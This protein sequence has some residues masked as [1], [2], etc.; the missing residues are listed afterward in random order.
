MA[1][2]REVVAHHEAGHAVVAD[3]LRCENERVSI[4]S[5]GEA[6]GEVTHNYGCDIDE[7]KNDPAFDPKLGSV[8]QWV[9]E[10]EA[11]VALSGEIAQRRFRPDSVKEWHGGG[12]RC[13]VELV[14]DYLA[15]EEDQ[16]LRDAWEHVL[17][18]RTKRLVDENWATI[19]GLA[20]LLLKNSTIE[21][22]ENVKEAIADAALPEEHRGKK[23]SYKERLAILAQHRGNA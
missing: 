8:R 21:G 15:G 17:L 19:E 10:R 13:Q 4:V 1:I 18:I 7:V 23:L 3:Y 2:D 11:I 22:V 5:D 16:E 12:D 14:L 20:S 6:A 9:L